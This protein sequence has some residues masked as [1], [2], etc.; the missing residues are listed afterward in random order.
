MMLEIL[1]ANRRPRTLVGALLCLSLA[2]LPQSVLASTPPAATL[3]FLQPTNQAV[4]STL[5]EIPIM[6][7]ASATNDAF[8]S[9]DVLANQRSIATVSYCCSLCPCFF[10][11]P[12]QETILQIPV[13]AENGHP[14]SNP[15]Q[16]W[17]NVMPGVYQLTA[18]SVGEKGTVL[19]ASPVT[20]TVL[21]LRLNIVVQPDGSVTLVIPEGSLV[22]AGYYLEASPDLLA[23]TRLGPF[24][25]GNLA[26]FYHD[27]PPD[28]AR[29]MRFYR[30]VYSPPQTP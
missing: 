16:G 29:K 30:S 19:E 18:R 1:T 14:P 24:E 2:L 4:F 26:A 3:E 28:N 20:I 5:D 23:W 22:P 25:P 15:W 21:D 11:E 9:G 7:R 8:L 10:P 13:P 6:L 12:G 27:V 17:T